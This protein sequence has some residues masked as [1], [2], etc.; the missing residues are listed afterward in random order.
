M[1][2]LAQ[3]RQGIATTISTAVPTIH[4]Y[5]RAPG[6]V[7]LP[8]FVVI[9]RETD[10]QQSMGRGLDVYSFSVIVLT[11]A[12]DD[13]L[14]QADLDE[15]INGF[16]SKSIRQAIFANRTLGLANVD[17]SVVGM[18]DYGARFDVADIDHVGARL[19]V[20]VHTTGTA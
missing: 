14:A 13:D 19:L 20:D 2:S 12:R 17:A 7:N 10:F 18:N 15:F 11:S 6:T 5:K 9:P 8:A 16:G 3:I 1:A 4:A